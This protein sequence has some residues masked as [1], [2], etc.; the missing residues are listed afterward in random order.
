MVG[1]GVVVVLKIK[2]EKKKAE[3]VYTYT[4]KIKQEKKIN[5][6][7]NQTHYY[8]TESRKR[9]ISLFKSQI[10]MLLLLQKLRLCVYEQAIFGVRGNET[11]QIKF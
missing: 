5:V 6:L 8:Y 3:R 1:S 11:E 10:V 7:N 9:N 2:F 4:C